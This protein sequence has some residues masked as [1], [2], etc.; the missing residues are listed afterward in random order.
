MLVLRFQ[1]ITTV[2]PGLLK[3]LCLISTP[4]LSLLSLKTQ[5]TGFGYITGGKNR[6]ELGIVVV[7][8]RPLSVFFL[9]PL[10]PMM[11]ASALSHTKTVGSL[12]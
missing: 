5:R 6:K 11:F 4:S 1:L 9:S 3:I 2:E 8:R 7:L 10:L 12:L